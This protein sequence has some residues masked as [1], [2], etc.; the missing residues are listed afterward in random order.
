MFV[1]SIEQIEQ[2][3]HFN[4]EIFCGQHALKSEGYTK[5]SERRHK[6]VQCMIS[7]I[8]DTKTAMYRR[9]HIQLHLYDVFTT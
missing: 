4:G 8:I 6:G 1:Q 2:L 3:T 7:S 9:V 5:S